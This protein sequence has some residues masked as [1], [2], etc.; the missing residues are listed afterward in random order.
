MLNILGGRGAGLPLTA[1]AGV[2]GLTLCGPGP[3]DSALHTANLVSDTTTDTNLVNGWG[4][5]RGTTSPWWISDN[6]TGKTTL[7]TGTGS[8]VPLV[9]TIPRRRPQQKSHRHA[10][11]PGLQRNHRFS[12]RQ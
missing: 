12:T 2:L 1:F 6:G 3:T 4:M 9:V 10:H 7:Y 5:S 11:W 8:I